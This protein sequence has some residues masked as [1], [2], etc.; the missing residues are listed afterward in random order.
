PDQ[1]RESAAVFQSGFEFAVVIVEN[2][3]LDAQY[4]MG[5]VHFG[6]ASLGQRAAG[7]APMADVSVCYGDKKHVMPL[8]GPQGRSASCLNLA[9]VRE[10]PEGSEAKFAIFRRHLNTWNLGECVG[11]AQQNHQEHAE[12]TGWKDEGRS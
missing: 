7:L 10:N 2:H 3:A 1:A 12:H 11:P 8:F 9:V 6:L 4:L 5:L